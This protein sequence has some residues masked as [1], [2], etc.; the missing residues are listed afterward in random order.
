MMRETVDRERARALMMAA[1]DDEISEAERAE[2]HTLI[3]AAPDL[4][5]EWRRLARV[6]EVTSGLTLQPL[7]EE[8]W[9]RYW[10][11]VYARLERGLAWV[12]VSTGAIV[13]SAYA[14]WQAVAAFLADTGEPW[15][16]RAAIAALALG[17]T[18][19]LL[20][21]IREKFWLSRRDPYQKEIM[22]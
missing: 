17:G 2:L 13:L 21:V 3:A 22:R 9:D 11:S 19:L 20:S 6:K 16:V 15:F 12:L 4:D 14:I 10:T 7:P 5:A 8:M 1:L 18:I